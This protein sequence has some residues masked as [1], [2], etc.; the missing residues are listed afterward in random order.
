[1]INSK[2]LIKAFD[3]ISELTLTIVFPLMSHITR[4]FGW[5]VTRQ[6]KRAHSPSSTV[7]GSGRLTNTGADR[8]LVSST[9]LSGALFQ[10]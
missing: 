6:Q 4:G 9:V 8:G 10:Y 1:M 2:T 7:T 3:H 5:P